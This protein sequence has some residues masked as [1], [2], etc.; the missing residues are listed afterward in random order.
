MRNLFLLSTCLF[1]WGAVAAQSAYSPWSLEFY[2]SPQW[3]QYFSRSETLSSL[4]PDPAEGGHFSFSTG[5]LLRR[6]LR[7]RWLVDAGLWLGL[8]S[9]SLSGAV[10]ED[11]SL[12]GWG[13]QS[14]TLDAQAPS[15]ANYVFLELPLALRY[16]WKNG[17]RW[18]AY[19]RG[20]TQL[21][22]LY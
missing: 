6:L 14:A 20:D 5:I 17:A 9:E 11:A 8:A 22:F 13:P 10:E 12:G 21:E 3:S 1:I 18:R 7:P 4:A 16:Y 2:G 19:L 15:R